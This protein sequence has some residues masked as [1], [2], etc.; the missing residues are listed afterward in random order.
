RRFGYGRVL[1]TAAFGSAVGT[2]LL[3]LQVTI[4]A[5]VAVNLFAGLMLVLLF[6]SLNT[7]IQTVVPNEYRG[8]V[9]ALYTLA[10][11]GISPFSALLLGLVANSIGTPA[12]MMLFGLTGAILSGWVV[13]RWPHILNRV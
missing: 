9:L 13:A 4:P 3:A 1:V 11:M 12:A 7:S 8:R 10:F 5:S 2:C 6:V